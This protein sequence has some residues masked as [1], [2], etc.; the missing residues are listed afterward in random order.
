M[1]F[2]PPIPGM[3]GLPAQLLQPVLV[4]TG[5]PTL[6]SGTSPSACPCLTP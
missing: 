3:D 2:Q 4:Q 5:P 6:V 1:D